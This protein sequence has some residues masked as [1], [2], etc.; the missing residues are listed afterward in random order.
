MANLIGQYH[1][2]ATW[3]D[4]LWALNGTRARSHTI[5]Q[6]RAQT[7][8]Y[9]NI[10]KFYKNFLRAQFLPIDLVHCRAHGQE[11]I[12]CKQ[13]RI[14]IHTLTISKSH[15]STAIRLA[16]QKRHGVNVSVI[17][18]TENI[19]EQYYTASKYGAGVNTSGEG[20]ERVVMGV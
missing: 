13:G 4:S 5:D 10:C 19:K 18:I 17:Q 20:K 16:K 9:N 8:K 15:A 14:T 3:T 7:I 1:C 6:Y 11:E 12:L 2:Y